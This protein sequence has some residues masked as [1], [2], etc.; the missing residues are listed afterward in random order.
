MSSFIGDMPVNEP[1]I[2]Q[3]VAVVKIMPGETTATFKVALYNFNSRETVEGSVT[4]CRS[5]CV[6]TSVRI[7]GPARGNVQCYFAGLPSGILLVRSSFVLEHYSQGDPGSVTVVK[8][9]TDYADMMSV[10]LTLTYPVETESVFVVK[11]GS[12][13]LCDDGDQPPFVP[14]LRFAER[15]ATL[16]I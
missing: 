11:F 5:D 6:A 4:C 1:T 13:V 7:G 9:E 14:G 3:V 12:P 8:F 15:R 2:G 16:R 10:T